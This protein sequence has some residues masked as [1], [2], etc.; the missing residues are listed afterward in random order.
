[1]GQADGLAPPGFTNTHNSHFK[2]YLDSEVLVTVLSHNVLLDMGQGG[3]KDCFRSE[4]S[5]SGRLQQISRIWQGLLTTTRSTAVIDRHLT[6]ACNAMCVF[7]ECACSS[8][9]PYV[10]DFGMSKDTW[11]Q[12]FEAI[13][14]SFEEAKVKPMRQVLITLATLLTHHPDQVLS[15]SIQ[16]EVMTKM[17]RIVLLGEAGNMK[18]ALVVIEL[19]IRRVSSFDDVLLSVEYCLHGK[20]VEWSRRLASFGVEKAVDD[21]LVSGSMSGVASNEPEWR[22]TTAFVVAL[23]MAL[24]S[25]DT[26]SAAIAL[27]KTY[28]TALIESGRGNH[29]YS[30][31]TSK[32]EEKSEAGLDDNF[33]RSSQSPWILLVQAFLEIYPAAV[34]PFT[35]FLFP[36]IFKQDPNSYREYADTLQKDACNLIN[37]L[38]VVQVGC[39]MGLERGKPSLPFSFNIL[40]SI[41]NP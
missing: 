28:A 40:Q 29:L 21:L 35:D 3:L 32:Q 19:F 25:R 37:L 33:K 2:A 9:L 41:S 10:R 8:V 11:L 34:T 30:M 12:C 6:A 38:A 18:A 7:L 13:L 27:Y 26:Q 15:S 16:Q 14:E 5:H 24:L 36:A 39:H 31:S 20:R 22:A 23:L 1:M 17:A 4:D